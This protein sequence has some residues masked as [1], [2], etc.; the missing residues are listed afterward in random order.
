MECPAFYSSKDRSEKVMADVGH[1]CWKNSIGIMSYLS[2]FFIAH[3]KVAGTPLNT[4][5]K[6]SSEMFFY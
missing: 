3:V 4:S 6:A 5:I 2:V 1:N